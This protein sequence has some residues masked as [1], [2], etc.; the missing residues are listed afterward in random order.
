MGFGS[1][2]AQRGRLVLLENGLDR[3]SVS[4]IGLDEHKAR[5]VAH[6][7]KIL[8]VSCICQFIY[9]NDPCS[10][11]GERQPDEVAANESSSAGHNNC[12]HKM[13][14]SLRVKLTETLAPFLPCTVL[15]LQAILS[16]LPDSLSAREQKAEGENSME[17]Y[18]TKVLAKRWCAHDV[19]GGFA[20][21]LSARSVEAV[22]LK[23]NDFSSSHNC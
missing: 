18:Y 10:S 17:M 11:P 15:I 23:A 12:F 16:L 4:N 3:R 8:P 14:T 7:S 20:P 21:I 2:I 13:E 22:E 6:L 19:R 9:D 5:V 1:Q